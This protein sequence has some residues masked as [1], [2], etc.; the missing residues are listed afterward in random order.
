M[1]PHAVTISEGDGRY[2]VK[3]DQIV[4]NPQIDRAAFEFPRT[5]GD[6]CPTSRR[7]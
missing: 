6:P 7:Y 5:S 3:L 2:E 1:E 4:H